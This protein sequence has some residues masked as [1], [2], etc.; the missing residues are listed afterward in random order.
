MNLGIFLNNT[1]SEIKYNINLVNFNNLKNNFDKII[2][3]DI[4]N[5]YSKKL[6]TI[7]KSSNENIVSYNID[8]KYVKDSNNDFEIN[9]IINVLNII[10]CNE[11]NYLSF[12]NDNYNLFF[13]LLLN[14]LLIKSNPIFK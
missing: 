11:Y 2:L 8:N 13:I 4:D 12:I 10:D 14:I 6:N 7:L 5:E 9:L 3:V 1:N